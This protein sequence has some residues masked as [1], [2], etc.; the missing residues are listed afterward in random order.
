M[1][2]RKVLR[3][4]KVGI[5]ELA[6]SPRKLKAL[7]IDVQPG[8]L[9]RVRSDVRFRT[10]AND[11]GIGLGIFARDVSDVDLSRGDFETFVG[12]VDIPTQKTG[13]ATNS[14]SG[15][16]LGPAEMFESST[17]AAGEGIATLYA[18]VVPI[19]A[20]EIG[21]AVSAESGVTVDVLAESVFL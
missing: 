13:I 4:D 1:L 9:Y 5:Y 14:E 20:C 17:K 12:R 21:L 19:V 3:R 10:A 8:F 16:I 15:T 11:A 7:S 2:K 18:I 6:G